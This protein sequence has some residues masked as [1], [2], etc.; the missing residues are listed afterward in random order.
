MGVQISR[1]RGN[2]GGKGAHCEVQGHSVVTCAKTAELIEMPFGL[3]AR[4][5]SR[6]HGG[7][8]RLL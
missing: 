4:S 6:N 5:G 2:F 1:G 3:C 7:K 8:G